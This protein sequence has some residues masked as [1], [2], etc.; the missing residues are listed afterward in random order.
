LGGEIQLQF[1]QEHFELGVMSEQQLTA[2]GGRRVHVDHL[3]GGELLKHLVR[4]Q[5][6]QPPAQGDV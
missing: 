1:V 5:R 3:H 6:M 4:G 2:I